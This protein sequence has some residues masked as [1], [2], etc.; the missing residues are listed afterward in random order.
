MSK[1]CASTRKGL[2]KYLRGHLFKYEQVR[3]ARHLN[4]CPVCRSEFQ[5]LQKVADTRQL[6]RD[7]TPPEGVKQ[8]L[9][10]GAAG[11]SKLKVLIYRPLWIILLVGGVTLL[12]VNLVAPRHDVEIENIEKSLPPALPL[13][14][15]PAATS[16]VAAAASAEAVTAPP[17]ATPAPEPLLVAV[18][19][20]DER[21]VA[22]IN[23][24]MRG[25][26]QLKKMK[27]S[28]SVRE[29]AGSLNE[30]E[31]ATFFERMEQTA[32][33]S[34]SKKKL[35]AFSG[36]DV[37][38]FII[39]LKPLRASGR[40]PAE[41]ASPAAASPAVATAPPSPS[42]DTRVKTAPQEPEKKPEP[43]VTGQ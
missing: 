40:N 33:V 3:I 16:R 39:K 5:A 19:P 38:P 24:I 17:P 14:S 31:L 13:V 11:L 22:R 7:I 35:Q 18:V 1:D 20:R 27:F 4:A 43:Q 34:Y 2:R 42:A 41:S 12:Y 29:V 21:S 6:L 30:K 36:K 37:I 26:G 28:E 9:K 15:A 25:H 8:R 10:A 32:S 23:E